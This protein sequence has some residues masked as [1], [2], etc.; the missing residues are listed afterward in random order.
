VSIEFVENNFLSNADLERPNPKRHT[1]AERM[2]A[3][4]VPGVSI[5]VI[6]AGNIEWA[7]GYGVREVGKPELVDTE[8]LF[9]AG[10]I[11]K[12]VAVLAAL[13]LVEQGK[14]ELDA[15]VNNYLKSW[16]IPT[17][18]GWQPRVT[19]RQL[20]SHRGGT[21]VSGFLGYSH[22]E[23]VPSLAQILN[24]VSPANSEPIRVDRMPGIG[25]SYSGGGTTIVQQMMLDVTDEDFDALLRRLVFEP[26]GMVHST[27]R[28]PLPAAY[29]H[30][31]AVGHYFGGTPVVG[32]W[33]TMPELAAAGLWT[34]PS[35]MARFGIA[36]WSAHHGHHPVISQ[37][38]ASW[39]VM[40]HADTEGENPQLGLGMMMRT[41]GEAS[42]FGHGG[43]NVGY[44]NTLMLFRENGDGFA[45]MTNGDQGDELIV[46][47][48][49]VVAEAYDWKFFKVE[50]KV[51]AAAMPERWQTYT[52]TYEL[53]A[54]SHLSVQLSGSTLMLEMM[55]QSPL[56]LVPLSETEFALH[57]LNTRVSFQPQED[58]AVNA[59]ILKQEGKEVTAKRV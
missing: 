36:L 59:L 39:M 8:T 19:L 31:A 51:I 47:I 25:F 41:Q 33:N 54:D 56:N 52:G 4:W 2:K 15:D 58:G 55:G 49:R 40:P 21:T 42:Y 48:R 38:V 45:V 6:K 37:K 1:L 29:H 32:R 3:Y 27:Y 10:S 16:K 18:N 28:Q 12:P 43:A 53:F 7:R 11:S 44:R 5:A 30:R 23:Q 20:L 34:T 24:G 26:L 9:Q 35:D 22:N 14:L 17:V 50:P 46:E 57:T 13:M